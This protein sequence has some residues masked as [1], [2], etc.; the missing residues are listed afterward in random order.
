MPCLGRPGVA[1]AQ[2]SQGSSGLTVRTATGSFTGLINDDYKDVREFRNIPYAQSPTGKR[3]WLPPQ[4]LPPSDDHHYSYRF[5]P[6]CAQYLTKNFSIWR[7]ENSDYFID[8]NGQSFIAGAQA[9]TSSED[10]LSMAVWTPANATADEKLPVAVFLS[11]GDFMVGGIT[12]NYQMP[13]PFVSAHRAIVITVNYRLNIFGFP[14]AAGLGDQNLG[15][16]DVRLALEWL[17]KNVASFGGDPDQMILWGQ[18]AG[19]VMADIMNYAYYDDPIVKGYYLM[20]GTAAAES[21]PANSSHFTLVSKSVGC[22]FPDDPAAELDCMRQVPTELI[23]NFIGQYADNMEWPLLVW[24]PMV[25]E[26]IYFSSYSERARQKLMSDRPALISTTSHEDRGIIG[27][28][29]TLN[30]SDGQAPWGD[31][32][33]LGSLFTFVCPACSTTDWRARANRTTYRSQYAGNFTNLTPVPW[34]GAFHGSDIPMVFGTYRRRSD[35]TEYQEDVSAAMQ[36]F[37]FAFMKDPEHGLKRKG[38][39]PHNEP[40]A[41]AGFMMRFAEGDKGYQNISSLVV[42][43]ICIGKGNFSNYNDAQ[44]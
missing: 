31:W 35:L 43:G 8:V 14:N 4:A 28:F 39:L 42:D 7:P 40:V 19:A 20:S 2:P 6:P 23:I 15:I 44:G 9:Q 22:D 37:L 3:R 34:I 25:D 30:I 21:L 29:P 26:K 36:D 41:E 18:S 38:W 5:P 33:D 17:R 24:R 1:T 12:I 32:I 10:C 16:R 27:M 11:G 13:A